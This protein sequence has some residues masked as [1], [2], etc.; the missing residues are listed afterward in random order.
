MYG[1]VLD[2][3]T[4]RKPS[5]RSAVE[6]AGH[7]AVPTVEQPRIKATFYLSREDILVID[8]LQM[9][10][11]MDTGKKPERSHIMSRALQLLARE[12]QGKELKTP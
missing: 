6:T 5:K 4:E 1:D 9:S 12:S 3:I 2:R 10:A 8:R 7:P 11:F